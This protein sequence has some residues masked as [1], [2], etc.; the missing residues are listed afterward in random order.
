MRL[1][2]FISQL[3]KELTRG[4]A[5]VIVVE[6]SALDTAKIYFFTTE[7]QLKHDGDYLTILPKTFLKNK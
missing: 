4:D 7:F 2:E 6:N 3:Q 5:T 1:S